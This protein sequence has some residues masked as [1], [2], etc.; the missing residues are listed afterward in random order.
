MIKRYTAHCTGLLLVQPE[1]RATYNENWKDVVLASDYDA[2]VNAL[3]DLVAM[4]EGECPSLM[5]DNHT[6]S[7]AYEILDSQSDRN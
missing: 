4:I 2:A 6:A 7:V 1:S 5:E 3:R